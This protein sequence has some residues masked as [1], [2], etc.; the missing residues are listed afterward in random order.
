MET[1]IRF[2]LANHASPSGLVLPVREVVEDGS[3]PYR[4]Y[5]DI[6]RDSLGAT[7]EHNNTEV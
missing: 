3:R 5:R 1:V 2:L 6:S 7:V 4:L